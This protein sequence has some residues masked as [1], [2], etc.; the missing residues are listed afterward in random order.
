MSE[1]AASAASI[2]GCELVTTRMGQQS[3]L[4]HQTGEVM[5]PVGRI[6]AESLYVTPSRL[7]ERLATPHR[8]PLVLL[9]VGLGA[10]SNAI[11]AWRVSEALPAAAR[12]LEIISVDH[13]LAP[14]AL[15]L[16]PE[17]AT[18][19]GL[20][21]RAG[22]AA[23]S[24]L[25]HPDRGYESSRTRWRLLLQDLTVALEGLSAESVDVVFWDI[26]SPRTLPHFWTE[27]SLHLLRRACRAGATVHTYSGALHVRA[28]MLLAGFAVGL[29]P[30]SG[31]KQR[32]TTIAAS[33]LS[34]L[35]APLGAD[36]LGRLQAARLAGSL[37]MEDAAVDRLFRLP[38][39]LG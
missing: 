19:F 34:S 16:Q 21:G 29:G 32:H 31:G 38:Q 36:W 25:E 7:A 20:D 24:L 1:R 3:I 9:D 6:E 33:D 22:E 12:A 37:S 14:L 11:A 5:H 15:A 28:A 30:S 26:Y 8:E 35:E 13:S 23:R 4:D 39:F 17:Q 27:Q 2:E 10:A 18:A